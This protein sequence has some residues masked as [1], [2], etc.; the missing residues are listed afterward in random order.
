MNALLTGWV[1]FGPISLV[2]VDDMAFV[3]KCVGV[4]PKERL[5]QGNKVLCGMRGMDFI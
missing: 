1:I 3:P 4:F 5:K 2:S